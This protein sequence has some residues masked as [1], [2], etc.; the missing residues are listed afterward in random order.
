MVDRDE[1]LRM[2]ADSVAFLASNGKRVIYDAEHFFDG[3]T[4]DPEY[5]LACLRAAAQAGAGAFVHGR[6]SVG[7][8]RPARTQANG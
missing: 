6:F 5:A 2:I 4:D 1:N 3:Y 7:S 8:D